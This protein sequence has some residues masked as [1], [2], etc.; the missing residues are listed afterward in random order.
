MKALS[1]LSFTHILLTFVLA[2]LAAT[3]IRADTP[4]SR[5]V[6][7]GG[8]ITEIVYALGEEDRLIA[9]D[10]TSIYPPAALALPDVGYMRR[11][12]AEGLIAVDPDLIL[13]EEGSGP[14]ETIELLESASVP[15]TTIPD[16]F[17]RTAITAKIET[18]AHVLG[19]EEK[20]A[21]L[22]AKTDA[23]LKAAEVMAKAQTGKKRVM[24]ILSTQGGRIMASG[25]NTAAH[26]IIEL[27]GAE[28]ALESFDGY[29]P[30]TDEAIITAAP[31]VILMMDRGGDHGTTEQVLALPA[32]ASTPAGTTGSV[33]TMN[34]LY[35][36]GFGP[37][38]AQAAFDLNAALYDVQG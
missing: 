11:L 38:T 34:G 1:I 31:D 32:I 9:R 33:I 10:T 30:L 21:A 25:R 29:K 24:F 23:D 5:I 13:A 8:S 3:A 18:I 14:P 16:G 36:L 6:S 37:R 35:I 2:M 12:S 4:A 28:N 19:V 26:G 7:V 22:A 27:A 20:G 15:F 17:D